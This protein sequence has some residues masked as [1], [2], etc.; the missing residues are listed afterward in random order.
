MKKLLRFFSGGT[1]ASSMRLDACLLL[2]SL[3][4]FIAGGG[5]YALDRGLRR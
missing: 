3:Y 4:L 1:A 5:K 2:A